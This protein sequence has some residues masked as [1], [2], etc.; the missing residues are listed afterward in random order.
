MTQDH[1]CPVSPHSSALK[2]HGE[3]FV[4]PSM[5]AAV[6]RVSPGVTKLSLLW[7]TFL[8]SW[9]HRSYFRSLFIFLS[10]SMLEISVLTSAEKI[11]SIHAATW[12]CSGAAGGKVRGALTA[13]NWIWEWFWVQE[14]SG[15]HVSNIFALYPGNSGRAGAQRGSS[16]SCC[17][18]GGELGEFQP[19]VLGVHH[20]S[21]PQ[22]P[23]PSGGGT[24]SIC[25]DGMNHS[26]FLG[27]LL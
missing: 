15:A 23:W 17:S 19:G 27:P 11:S 10:R 3:S 18:W 7:C 14:Q 13:H 20:Q 12:Q 16:G 25:F 22:T 26:A 6:I 1:C 24:C 8:H 4:L 21:P 2:I 5:A 9:H